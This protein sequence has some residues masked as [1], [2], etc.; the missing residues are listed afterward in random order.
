MKKLIRCSVFFTLAA[1]WSAV[2]GLPA[3]AA[4][5]EK[6]PFLKAS[7][8]LPADLLKGSHHEIEDQVVNDGFMNHFTIRSDFGT[9]EAKS[10]ALVE[11]R[12]REVKGLADLQELSQTEV[13]V[14]ALGA[15]GRKTL[16]S[17]ARV[18]T[19]PVG[20]AKGVSAGVGRMFKRVS[21]KVEKTADKAA[22]AVEE[23]GGDP[24]G[25]AGAATAVAKDVVGFNSAKRS[26]ARRV[27]VDPYS[28]N[29]VLQKELDRLA[30]AAFA[31][32][33]GIGQTVGRIPLQGEVAAV[34]NMV[35]DTPPGDL[36]VANREKLAAMGA[37]KEK[38]NTWYGNPWYTPTT[39]T[40]LVELMRG[41]DGVEGRAGIL[42]LASKVE[43]DE[44]AALLLT[45]L[46]MLG[47]YHSSVKPLASI[48]AGSRLPLGVTEDGT[49]VVTPGVDHV[50]WTE[51]IAGYAG[52]VTK[53]L[54]SDDSL[55]AADLR[56]AGTLSDRAG[57]ELEAL[58]WKVQEK[59]LPPARKK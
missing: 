34:S 44:Q 23:E 24:Q 31:G 35:W 21:L 4:D 29:Q 36:E 8:L 47:D 7:E 5:Y 59:A 22:D 1:A 9:F 16:D 54:Q 6:P 50:V 48:Y 49:V 12:V 53:L 28:T 27:G 32:E 51:Q 43:N 18:V 30:W 25:A 42:T 58:G 11:I 39:Q 52:A 41:F 15:A 56:I 55:K 20:T 38:V 33:V 2:A 37:S 26:L 57:K 45:T 40:L 10:R 17:A 19:D 14:D 3:H 13:F 46:R